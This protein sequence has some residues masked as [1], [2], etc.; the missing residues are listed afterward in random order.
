MT[1]MVTGASG[2]LGAN[3]VLTAVDAGE[4]VTA[5]SRRYR[6]RAPG[7]TGIEVDLTAPGAVADLI[8]RVHPTTIIH[9]A[10]IA[11]VDA[12][13]RDPEACFRHN[14]WMAGEVAAA[15]RAAGARLIHI[16]TE[17]VFAGHG[18]WHTEDDPTGPV[19]VYGHSKLAGEQAVLASH[20]EALV[21]RT[22]LYGWNA[23]PKLSLAEWFLAG[24]SRGERRPGFQD[25]WM[26]P[27]EATDFAR[28]LLE[29]ARRD[30]HG[31]LHV[32]GREC[33]TKAS[34]GQR[35]AVAFGYDP[36]LVDPVFTQEGHLAAPRAARPCLCVDRVEGMLGVRMPD[37]DAG[38][39][40]FRTLAGEGHR[41]RLR[42][43]LGGAS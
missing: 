34:F 31:I 43:M 15:A 12:C 11:G 35:L 4:Q 39:E 24:F 6:L 21:V 22:R 33:V 16:S 3:L 7:V 38:I 29:L 13:E 40:R 41:E 26:N 9:A 28:F 27:L 14:T 23:Q 37:L 17:A 20:P 2:L 42:D 18:E 8:A 25:S 30:V 19:N 36:G 5:I 10:A 1:L 32:A